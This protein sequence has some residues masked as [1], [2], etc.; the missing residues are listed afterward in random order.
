MKDIVEQNCLMIGVWASVTRGLRADL[1]RIK[2]DKLLI[3]LWIM[4]NNKIPSILS[5]ST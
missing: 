2:L 1:T 4:R 5:M 3:N